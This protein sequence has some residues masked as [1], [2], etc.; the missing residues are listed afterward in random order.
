MMLE[1]FRLEDED[2]IYFK[3]SHTSE[4]IIVIFFSTKVS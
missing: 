2:G 3:F 1:S 4:S